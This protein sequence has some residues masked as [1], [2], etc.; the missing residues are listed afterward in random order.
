MISLLRQLDFFNPIEIDETIHVI[1]IGA[2]G[3]FVSIFL[4]R[5]G[6]REIHIW[7]FDNVE[8][9]NIPN[10]NYYFDNLTEEKT[11]A[12]AKEVTR[13]NPEIKITIHKEYKEDL[14]E[15]I[16]FVCVDDIEVRKKLYEANEFNGR[17]KLVIDTRIGLEDGQVYIA[18][19][20]KQ[21][22][23]DFLLDQSQFKKGEADVPV[24]A[25]GTKLAVLPTVIQA[26]NTAITAFINYQKD[27]QVPKVVYYN[28][29]N[30]KIKTL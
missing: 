3:S 10:Q 21:E 29:F 17:L 25:C 7:D 22:N 14:I 26:A 4:A 9:H 15:G 16:A 12:I 13:V 23:I 20:T 18:N 11:M 24:S 8:E 1:G 5:L 30:N 27:L 2:V 28:T 19:W 6:V